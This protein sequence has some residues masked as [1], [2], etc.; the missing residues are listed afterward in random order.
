MTPKQTVLKRH[1]HA[2]CVRY[3]KLA[4]IYAE[5]LKS[6]PRGREAMAVMIGKGA[7]PRAAWADACSRLPRGKR[8]PPNVGAKR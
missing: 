5:P 7:S 3:E 4:L 6:A 2:Y 1:P 8:K